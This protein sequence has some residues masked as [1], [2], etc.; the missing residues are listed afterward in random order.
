MLLIGLAEWTLYVPQLAQMILGTQ[1]VATDERA[2]RRAFLT[3]A[4]R[5]M[6]TP[7]L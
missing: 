3:E 6:L 2:L 5:K 7:P 4:A 1:A